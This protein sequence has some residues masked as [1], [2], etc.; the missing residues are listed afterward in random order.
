MKK[1]LVITISLAVILVI[2]YFVYA[3]ILSIGSQ[4]M[5][6]IEITEELKKLENKIQKETN[7]GISTY[8]MPIQ[9]HKIKDCN[10]KLSLN[11]Y[12]NKDSIIKSKQLLDNYIFSIS[13]RVNQKL[14][15]KKCLDSLIINVSFNNK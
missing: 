1:T 3:I 10:G 7:S 8:F 2:G 11:V 9:K 4:R 12:V 6:D 15:N 5:P 13:K 14:E